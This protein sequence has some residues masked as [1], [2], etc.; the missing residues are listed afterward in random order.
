VQP[1]Q[2]DRTDELFRRPTTHHY[3]VKKRHRSAFHADLVPQ[4]H[5]AVQSLETV[6]PVEF[7]VLGNTEIPRNSPDISGAVS[8]HSCS[9]HPPGLR[10]QAAFRRDDL[11]YRGLT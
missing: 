5:V 7:D 6:A 4:A 11:N 1:F 2:Q 10:R 8:L 3:A 9:E